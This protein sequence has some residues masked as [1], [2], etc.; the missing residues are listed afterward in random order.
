MRGTVKVKFR[1]ILAGT[2]LVVGPVSTTRGQ[3]CGREVDAEFEAYSWPYQYA[4]QADCGIAVG[5][6]HILTTTNWGRRVWD[7]NGGLLVSETLDE[8]FGFAVAGDPIVAF[9][10]QSS[11]WFVLSLVGSDRLGLGVSHTSDPVDRNNWDFH[12]SPQF[13]FFPDY[14]HMSIGAEQVFF[15][16]QRANEAGRRA[17]IAWADKATLLN[18]QLPPVTRHLI[19]QIPNQDDITYIRASSAPMAIIP[20][21]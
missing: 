6:D 4:L 1:M 17:E 13:P 2:L 3:E 11:R 5:P 21:M 7:R 19:E 12:Q 18:G 10:Q 15:S 14:P 16:W 9:D 20:I 8:F